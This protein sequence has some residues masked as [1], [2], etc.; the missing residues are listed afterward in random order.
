MQLLAGAGL[1]RSSG[2]H[3]RY[4]RRTPPDLRLVPAPIAP[5]EPERP[6]DLTR[7]P[8]HERLPIA[9]FRAWVGKLVQREQR[10]ARDTHSIYDGAFAVV[11]ERL[12]FSE[13]RLYALMREQDHISLAIADRA[14]LESG[15]AVFLWD[16]WPH[17]ARA[18]AA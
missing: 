15:E 3:P 1:A 2:Q 17:L 8:E 12:G 18:R 11:A 4:W 14:L 5:P 13:R 9:P 10:R 16:L 6:S 7:P